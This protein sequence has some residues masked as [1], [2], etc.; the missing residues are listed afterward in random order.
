MPYKQGIRRRFCRLR[1]S[2]NSVC[3]LRVADK[4]G[5]RVGI[6]SILRTEHTHLDRPGLALATRLSDI[7]N[8]RGHALFT[9]RRTFGRSNRKRLKRNCPR[10]RPMRVFACG[11][12][13]YVGENAL[14]SAKSRGRRPGG[15]K[16]GRKRLPLSSLMMMITMTTLVR[17]LIDSITWLVLLLLL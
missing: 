17:P 8:R 4:P 13:P 2:T 11:G 10:S 7:S 16:T 1:N 6:G 15:R 3:T 5:S 12:Q 14:K 9:L